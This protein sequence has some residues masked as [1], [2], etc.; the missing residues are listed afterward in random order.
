MNAF[1]HG[2]E[3]DPKFLYKSIGLFLTAYCI[4]YTSPR[5]LHCLGRIKISLLISH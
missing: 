2:D 4:G 1:G 5:L 3:N